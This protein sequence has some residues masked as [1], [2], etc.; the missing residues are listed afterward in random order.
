MAEQKELDREL[1]SLL[2]K[3]GVD[4]RTF[5][6]VAASLQAE[7]ERPVPMRPAFKADLR[8]RLMAEAAGRRPARWFQRPALWS[9]VGGAAAVAVLVV[10]LRVFNGVP[11]TPVGEGL[12]PEVTA[13]NPAPTPSTPI[14]L[15]DNTQLPLVQVP[16]EP[17]SEPPL[18]IAGLESAK[19]LPTYILTGSVD[20]NLVKG[21][22]ERLAFPAP[23]PL[24]TAGAYRVTDGERLLQVSRTG[25]FRYED[26]RAQAGPA[27]S[28]TESEAVQAATQFLQSAALPVVDLNPKVSPEAEAY[29]V[30]YQ[31]R[32]EGRLVI[33]GATHVWV[34]RG[35]SVHRV[36]SFTP[37]GEEL[38]GSY[39]AIS[40]SDAIALAEAKGGT[41]TRGD[42]VWVRTPVGEMVYLQPYWRLYGETSAE[43]IVRYVPALKR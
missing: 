8:A 17:Q 35:G 22:A 14:H 5:A 31:D 42:L 6:G 24:A 12:T 43:A 10:G 9:T 32:H 28:V 33:G 16:D 40:Y 34:G 39:E 11:T 13:P 20:A 23:D 26:R 4:P 19:Q 37:S 29:Q 18:S 38:K 1:Y 27:L 7:L 25:A 30:T 41:F 36:E 2:K 21:I 15:V 3:E